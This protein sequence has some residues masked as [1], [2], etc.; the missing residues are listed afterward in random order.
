M[1]SR[2]HHTD[3]LVIGWGLSGLVAAAEALEAGRRVT[4]IDQEPR[5]N[6]GGQAWWSF[7][8][9]FLVDSP[10]QRRMGIR[11]SL[12]LATQ[13]WFGNAGFDRPEDEWPRRWA[14][15]YLEFAAGEKRSWL[16]ER[17][18]GFAGGGGCAHLGAGVPWWVAAP[19]GPEA[20]QYKA[21]ASSKPCFSTLAVPTPW[22]TT[23]AASV[24]PWIPGAGTSM[25]NVWSIL[26]NGLLNASGTRLER[27]GGLRVGRRRGQPCHPWAISDLRAS[28]QWANSPAEQRRWSSPHVPR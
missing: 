3:V 27:T 14:S 26:N 12:E 10:E 23:S 16:R 4:V 18:V 24:G 22:Y 11:D 2:T 1:A 13:D 28:K 8:G 6:L 5:S 15:A 9:L 17:G 19:P 7:G 25:E 21:A 20:M